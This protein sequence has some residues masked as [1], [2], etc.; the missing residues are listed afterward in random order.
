MFTTTKIHKLLSKNEHTKTV[1]RGTYPI[2]RLPL[3]GIVNQQK[4]AIVIVNLGESS[5]SG[6]HW[7]LLFFPRAAPAYMFDS[8]GRRI[9]HQDLE[10]FIRRNSKYGLLTNDHK[11][12]HE[13]SLSCGKFV[14]VVAYL[15]SRGILPEHIPSLFSRNTNE[16]EKRVEAMMETI[17]T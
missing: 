1:Y 2:D 17:F 4:P 15:L 7:I 6:S 10:T 11:L 5:T 14:S 3:F 8:F 9:Q 16:N 12:Q 13:K